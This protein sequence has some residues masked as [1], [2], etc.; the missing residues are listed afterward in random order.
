MNA[1]TR[2]AFW[3]ALLLLL[4]KDSNACQATFYLTFFK[5]NNVL[6]L[7]KNALQKETTELPEQIYSS[8]FF[9]RLRIM[10]KHLIC[11]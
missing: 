11:I 5:D 4:S 9:F 10:C 3:E 6:F 7:S 2:I 1:W 8:K